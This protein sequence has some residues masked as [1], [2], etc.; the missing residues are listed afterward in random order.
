LEEL[1]KKNITSHLL[2]NGAGERH[3][4]A[5]LEKITS[6]ILQNGTGERH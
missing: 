6:L 3:G 5:E 1:E 4:L 2:Q